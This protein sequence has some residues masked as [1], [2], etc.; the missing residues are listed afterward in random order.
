[1][2][3]LVSNPQ[4]NSA[5]D[6]GEL[7]EWIAALDGEIAVFDLTDVA[8]A[9]VTAGVPDLPA[10]TFSP[11]PL[12]AFRPRRG[13]VFQGQ[14]VSKSAEYRALEAAAIPVPR[15]TRLLP[16]KQPNL[17]GFGAHVVTKPDFGA[18]GADVRIERAAA[19][20]WTPP[21]TATGLEFGGPFNPRVVQEFVYTGAWPQSHRVATLFGTALWAIRVE[22]SHDR[23]PL[24][25]RT[26]F[27]GQSVV[28]SGHGCRFELCDD[29][30]VIALAERAHAAFPRVPLLG[31]DILRDVDTG[32]LFV[33]EVNSLGYTWHFSSPSGLRFQAEFGFDLNAQFDGRRCAARVLARVCSE[34]AV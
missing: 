18:R 15:W 10:V 26:S 7:R 2:C 31:A 1:M 32:E 27:N 11:A 6:F 28:S 34:H 4:V 21:R 12:R 23:Q 14:H 19:V 5:A 25:D 29:A 30:E 22:A 16:G 33:V 20:R 9:D 3:N 24:T 13:L 17:A 8:D